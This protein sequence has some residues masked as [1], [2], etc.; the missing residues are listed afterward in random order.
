MPIVDAHHHLWDP[1]LRRYP[2]LEPE[3]LAPIRRPYTLD[4]LRALSAAAGIDHTILVQAVATVE[5]TEELLRV[6]E[7][8]TGLIA[9]VVG[10]VDLTDPAVSET[11]ARLRAGPGGH[12]LVGI[13]H[14][15]QDEPDPE[16]LLRPAVLRGLRAVAD[17]ALTYDL[18]VTPDQ[19][20]TAV[21]AVREVPDGRYVLDHAA[22]PPV[23]SGAQQPWRAELAELANVSEDIH[24][25]LSGLVTEADWAAWTLDDLRPYARTVFETFGASRVMFGTDWP[26]C[27]LAAGHRQVMDATRRLVDELAP[28][29]ANGVLGELATT[30]YRL[31]NVAEDRDIKKA[32]Q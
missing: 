22:K 20:P 17:A 6:A 21:A 9:G 4:H 3:A 10:W 26:V 15:V 2:F 18:L 7:R 31:S 12:L 13:R 29:H 23:A 27:E 25:K 30:A 5:E 24:C 16:W 1:A 28:G 14:Q 32:R 8:S 19:L 11:I